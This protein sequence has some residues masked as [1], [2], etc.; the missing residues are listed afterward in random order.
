DRDALGGLSLA[1]SSLRR[2][3]EL[4]RVIGLTHRYAIPFDKESRRCGIQGGRAGEI[5]RKC[6]ANARRPSHPA[7][8]RTP[9]ISAA[10][11]MHSN[12]WK[13]GSARA[14]SSCLRS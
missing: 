2:F 3:I 10:A 4:P 12:D 13:P 5:R 1:G 11:P 9:R 14:I 7:A 8:S 6:P